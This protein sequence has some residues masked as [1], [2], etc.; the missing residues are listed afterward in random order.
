M[1]NKDVLRFRSCDPGQAMPGWSLRC[2][3]RCQGLPGQIFDRPRHEYTSIEFIEAGTGTLSVR[4]QTYRL[5]AGDAFILPQGVDHRIVCDDIH[6]WRVLF[7]D[8]TGT[9]V[10]QLNEAYGLGEQCVFPGVTIAQPIRNL[11]NLVGDDAALQA[12]AGLTIHEVFA[13]LHAAIR[14]APDW[15][16]FIIKAKAFIDANLESTFRLADVA[17]H[18]GCSE[19]HLSR[20]F[21]RHVGTPPGDYLITRRMELAKALLDT[22]GE[23][24]KAIAERLGY[25]DSFAFSHA[26]KAVVGAAPSKWREVQ[27]QE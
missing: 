18:V 25:R 17:N 15:P 8:C 20:Q 26:F 7:L 14:R 9:L 19:A 1:W 27:H 10:A 11:L 24:V 16:E 22:T 13:L 5:G 6:P 3:A 23:S 4:G 21:R 2:V 12:R